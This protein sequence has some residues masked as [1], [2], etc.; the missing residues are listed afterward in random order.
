MVDSLDSQIQGGSYTHT[1]SKLSTGSTILFI[2]KN[3]LV[4]VFLVVSRGLKSY[5]SD[6][7]QNSKINYVNQLPLKYYQ[8]YR[9]VIGSFVVQ[10]IY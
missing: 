2:L 3:Y 5:I 9:R 10:Y 8:V 4:L 6:H 1:T 7:L